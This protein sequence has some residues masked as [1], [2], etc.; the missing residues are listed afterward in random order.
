MKILRVL[1]GVH[2]GVQ[3]RLAHATQYVIGDGGEADI[4]ITDWRAA[5]LLLQVDDN[6][7]ARATRRPQGKVPDSD[8][9]PVLLPDF[10][11][12][13]FDETVLCV[14]PADLPWPSDVDLLAPLWTRQPAPKATKR[15][16]HVTLG[17]IAT[18]AGVIALVSAGAMLPSAR[19]T[20]S[21]DNAARAAESARNLAEMLS[22]A[23]LSELHVAPRGQTVIVSG[24]VRNE[25]DEALAQ[26]IIGRAE[27]VPVIRR[28]DIA[29]A[30]AQNIAESLAIS[31][32]R[33]DYSGGGVFTVRG[34]VQSASK[35]REAVDRL[36][37]EF[38]TNVKRVDV[39]VTET[40]PAERPITYSGMI[41]SAGIGYFIS[42]D[43]TKHLL[44]GSQ[45]QH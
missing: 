9:I 2:A 31:G 38:G 35:V 39:K 15:S 36:L 11:A 24:M 19:A 29:T 33:I 25:A 7:V 4:C 17:I 8:S 5:K 40:P 23:G 20:Q 34:T 18:V 43:G 1:T 10:V 42:P 16:P 22:A 3:V 28:Y 21:P 37:P 44:E 13:N 27:S 30:D 45:A 26:G 12:V 32:A 14:G 41:E 6:G